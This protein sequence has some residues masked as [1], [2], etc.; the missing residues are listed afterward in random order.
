LATVDELWL[1]VLQRLCD[2][3]AHPFKGAMNGVVINLE[4]VRS[5]SSR[6][7]S[8]G[9]EGGGGGGADAAS[10]R[11]FAEAA[12]AEMESVIRSAE[13]LLALT[14][15]ARGPADIARIAKDIAT[16]AAPDGATRVTIDK[17][18]ERLATTSAP[19]SAVRMAIGAVLLAA[20]EVGN[21]VVCDAVA[22]AP[23]PTIR[24]SAGERDGSRFALND[25][26]VSAAY[27]AG[28]HLDITKSG[29]TITFPT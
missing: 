12:A 19:P 13:A 11:P 2:A 3:A 17:S 6:S 5:R 15:P 10:L 4:V 22:D 7:D 16:L 23:S 20:V 29:A 25:E 27:S 28:V 21:D 8:G 14:R 1:G 18:V 9:T 26:A 24:V